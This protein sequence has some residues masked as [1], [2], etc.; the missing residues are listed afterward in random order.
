MSTVK[1]T[2][3]LIKEFDHCTY[4]KFGHHRK[5]QGE[6]MGFF[7]CPKYCFRK[8]MNHS[9]FFMS[10]M[11]TIEGQTGLFRFGYQIIYEKDNSE[12]EIKRDRRV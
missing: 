6:T 5:I 10:A 7:H 4:V 8:G 2:K 1:K 12:L 11:S 3:E 9:V